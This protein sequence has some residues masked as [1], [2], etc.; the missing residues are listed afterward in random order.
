MHTLGGASWTG[1]GD[2]MIVEHGSG[3]SRGVVTE[4]RNRRPAA[5]R[6]F[7]RS[8]RVRVV[9]NAIHAKSGG[10]VTHLRNLLPHLAA[11]TRIEVHVFLHANQYSQFNPVDDR[12]RVHLFDFTEGFLRTL[13]WEQIVVPVMARSMRADVTF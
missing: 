8:D 3:P 4:D 10:G 9:I 11:D 12:V 1:D 6:D 5:R 13:F 2:V 7:R